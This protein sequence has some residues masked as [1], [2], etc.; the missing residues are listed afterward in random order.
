MLQ[1]QISRRNCQRD[2]GGPTSAGKCD[3]N[4][5]PARDNAAASGAN[6]GL[7]LTGP[8]DPVAPIH[9]QPNEPTDTSA[10][11][12]QRGLVL[13]RHGVYGGVDRCWLF[14]LSLLSRT[15]SRLPHT[16]SLYLSFLPPLLLSFSTLFH[17]RFFCFSALAQPPHDYVSVF[18]LTL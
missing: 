13:W 16:M 12:V 15:Q 14:R 1:L 4:V 10:C 6:D 8:N 18:S 3:D 5:T 9:S 7:A 17:V 2:H 11:Q